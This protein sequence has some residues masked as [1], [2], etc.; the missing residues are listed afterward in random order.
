MKIPTE[1][2]KGEQSKTKSNPNQNKNKKT[3]KP[4]NHKKKDQTPNQSTVAS[5]RKKG[6][7]FLTDCTRF[8]FV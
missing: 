2:E 7:M 8:A 1:R 4:T 5:E 3:L 6:R